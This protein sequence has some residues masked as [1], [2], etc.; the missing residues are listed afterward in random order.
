[1]NRRLPVY[2]LLDCSESMAGEA[3]DAVVSGIGTL[4]GELRRDPQALETACMSVITFSSVARQVM[5]LTDL[6]SFRLPRLRLGSGT[7]LG[8]ALMLWQQ[9]MARDVVKTS[10]TQKG[11]Y[12]P[13]CF[14]MTDG[15]PTDAWEVA[16]DQVRTCVAGKKANVIAVACGQDAVLAKLRRITETVLLMKGTNAG[17]FAQFFKWVSASVSTA[18]QKLE[19]GGAHGLGLPNPPEGVEI[20]SAAAGP[21]SRGAA[22]RQV[23]LHTRCMKTKGFY[24]IRYVRNSEGQGRAESGASPVY[25]AAAAH[26]VEDFESD[27]EGE[28]PRL[29]VSNENLV[30]SPACPYCGNGIWGMCP[31]GHVHCCPEYSGSVTLTCPWFGITCSYSQNRFDVGRGVG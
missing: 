13:V 5:P 2:L 6:M 3:F 1:M 16:A 12:K 9:C 14:I 29:K 30:G 20:A 17:A 8:G 10:A 11:D 18:S 25:R 26:K 4:A 23:F 24:L 21:L 19:Q 28:S 27:A 31:K 22:D 7:A 15:E